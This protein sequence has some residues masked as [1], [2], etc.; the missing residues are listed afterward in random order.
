MP[1]PYFQCSWVDRLLLLSLTPDSWSKVSLEHRK[2]KAKEGY[3][4]KS[5]PLWHS[6]GQARLC[7]ST[8]SSCSR[9]SSGS[10]IKLELSRPV[11]FVKGTHTLEQI[12][13]N[14]LALGS[15]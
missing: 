2:V 7:D 13:F 15:S 12:Y 1:V 6:R 4:S 3:S 9:W 14:T 5:D 10:R 8:I 11:M